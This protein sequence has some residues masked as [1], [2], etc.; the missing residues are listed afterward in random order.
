MQRG[1]LV[2]AAAL[3]AFPDQRLGLGNGDGA[4]LAGVVEHIRNVSHED[5]VALV[6]IAR[7]LAHEAAHAAALAGRDAHVPIVVLDVLIAALV[8]DLLRVG[9][10]GALDGDDAHDAGAHGGVGGVLD[11]AGGRVLMECIGDL[12]VCQAEFLVDQQEF[13]NAGGV[14][15][16]QID[17]QPYLGDDDLHH[18]SDL[19]DLVQDL[20]GALDGQARLAGDHGDKGRLHTGQRQHYGDL[21]VRDPLLEN[22]VLGAVGR[23]LVMPVVDFFAELDQILSHLQ[24][25]SLLLRISVALM[26]IKEKASAPEGGGGGRSLVGIGAHDL[27]DVPEMG[28]LA[29]GFLTFL[30]RTVLEG[31]RLGAAVHAHH[32]PAPAVLLLEQSRAAA[33]G[34]I[35]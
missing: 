30:R 5:A 14:G 12:G 1:D 4:A 13:K 3:F 9:G 8:V 28:G 18:K 26:R 34:T 10:D 6:Q 2:D 31:R 23:D 11:L 17:L 27:A 22:P 20:A 24:K 19:G 33:E 16:Q 35:L 25:N 15:R 7:A 32:I 29:G 21:L